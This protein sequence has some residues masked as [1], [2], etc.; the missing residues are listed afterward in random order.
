MK[1]DEILRKLELAPNDRLTGIQINFGYILASDVNGIVTVW[2]LDDV[3]D[4]HQD[5]ADRTHRRLQTSQNSPTIIS[6]ARFLDPSIIV[7]SGWDG[8]I[9]TWKIT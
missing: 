7:A 3:L 8:R 6:A 1:N 4:G 2:S 9:F 5:L